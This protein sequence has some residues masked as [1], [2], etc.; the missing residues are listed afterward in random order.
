MYFNKTIV[1]NLEKSYSFSTELAV[2]LQSIGVT[3]RSSEHA[4]SL[5][6]L[7]VLHCSPFSSCCDVTV[8]L[9][10]YELLQLLAFIA[11]GVTQLLSYSV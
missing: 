8:L 9:L 11:Q 1:C 10:L 4:L 7:N 6:C 3:G 5:L 2:P